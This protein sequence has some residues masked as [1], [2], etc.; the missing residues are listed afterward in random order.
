M[1]NNSQLTVE[2]FSKKQKA[3][4]NAA[5]RAYAKSGIDVLFK[6]APHFL[7]EIDNFRESLIAGGVKN[8]YIPDD[9]TP[10]A[11]QL[12]L[13]TCALLRYPSCVKGETPFREATPE[14]ILQKR[15]FA[16]F[17][18]ACIAA[19][20]VLKAAK[21]RERAKNWLKLAALSDGHNV[22]SVECLLPD[23]AEALAKG[24]RAAID[25]L[26]AEDWYEHLGTLKQ[27]KEDY[28]VVADKN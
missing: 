27:L 17:R 10:R 14:F 4:R 25:D 13:G 22:T 19:A 1:E 20:T 7:S 11:L 6:D 3:V 21:E 9:A 26:Y 23:D 15:L 28:Y 18:L 16:S 2:S 12:M 24:F 8:V 5:A